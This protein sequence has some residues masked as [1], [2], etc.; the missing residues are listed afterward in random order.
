MPV[1]AGIPVA[2][3]WHI[4]TCQ[5]LQK[6]RARWQGWTYD[7]SEPTSGAESLFLALSVF[8]SGVDFL[9]R[10][11]PAGLGQA[12]GAK[13][14]FP[15]ALQLRLRDFG[16]TLPEAVQSRSVSLT[17]FC[18]RARVLPLTVFCT[19]GTGLVVVFFRNS[20][21]QLFTRIVVKDLLLHV[22]D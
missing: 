5:C 19:G 10:P 4:C 16:A 6:S 8:V 20:T 9:R 2:Y 18:E 13:S 7:G 17:A 12:L 14:L 15:D 22:H 1:S 3:F 11:L 21:T